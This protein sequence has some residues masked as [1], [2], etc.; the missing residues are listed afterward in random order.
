[1]T[2]EIITEDFLPEEPPF[3]PEEEQELELKS[4]VFV[5][6]AMDSP[7]LHESLTYAVPPELQADILPGQLVRRPLK[8]GRSQGV[9]LSVGTVVPP[10]KVRA[11]TDLVDRRPVLQ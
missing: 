2:G 1:M 3:P 10:F 7:G 4:A 9:V 5:E 11:I 6:V 8:K